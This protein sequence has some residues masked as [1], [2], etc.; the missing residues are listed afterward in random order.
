M[1]NTDKLKLLMRKKLMTQ[2]ELADEIG[3]KACTFNQ[4]LNGKR[5]ISLDEA[6]AIA[7]ALDIKKNEI[8]D[9]FFTEIKK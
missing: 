2:A 1:I 3:V 9:Y 7:I 6:E 5:K 4:K 8:A